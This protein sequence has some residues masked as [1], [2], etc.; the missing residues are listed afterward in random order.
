MK[1]R[2]VM[3]N[4]VIRIHPEETV[5]V[6]ARTLARYNIGSL[7]VCGSDGRLCGVVT[8]RDLVT[9]C[10]ASGRAPGI[11][12][13]S[14]VMTAQVVSVRPDME[15]SE[16]AQ[17]MGSHQVRRLPVVENG[18]LCGMVSLSDLMGAREKEPGAVTALAEISGNLSHRK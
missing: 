17:V 8:D 6:A 2:D 4:P 12:P 9:R 5:A 3:T 14:Q 18:R 7:P 15:L 16:A 11:T 10:L 1:L 13:V